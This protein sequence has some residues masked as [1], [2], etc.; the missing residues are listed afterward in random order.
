[1]LQLGGVCVCQPLFR[2]ELIHLSIYLSISDRFFHLVQMQGVVARQRVY[3]QRRRSL[4]LGDTGT[5]HSSVPALFNFQFLIF[6]RCFNN[7]VRPTLHI[8]S[9]KV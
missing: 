9:V 5:D 1:M 7:S 8:F 2:R 4:S 3:H 6:I